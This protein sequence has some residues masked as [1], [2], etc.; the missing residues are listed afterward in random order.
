M[1]MMS[2]KGRLVASCF[3]LF[4]LVSSLFYFCFVIPNV[5]IYWRYGKNFFAF[6]E[7]FEIVNSINFSVEFVNNSIHY[8]S[9][10][11]LSIS[12]LHEL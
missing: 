1:C 7:F 2:E 6:N 9:G 11:C 3:H 4:A 8:S 5:F 10:I 12:I